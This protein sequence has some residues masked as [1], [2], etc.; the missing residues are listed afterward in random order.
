MNGRATILLAPSLPASISK[1]L[2]EDQALAG[3][4]EHTRPSG[5][6]QRAETRPERR[7]YRRMTIRLPV[8][9]SREVAGAPQIVRTVTCNVS[10]G[11]MYIEL[12]RPEFRVG[13]RFRIELTVPAGEGVSAYEGRASC[14][15]EVVRI[16]PP[17]PETVPSRRRYGVAARF[18][19]RLRF[20][21]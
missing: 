9:C 12:D 18:L 16:D 13:D 3:E 7:S 11:G 19:D 10:T 17:E 1:A 20:S 21:Y 2:V 6:L 14:A 5:G 15:G 8:E 4:F